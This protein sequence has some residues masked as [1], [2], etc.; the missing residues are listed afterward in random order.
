MKQKRNRVWSMLLT[1]ALLV[2]SFAGNTAVLPV[3]A[4][5]E[6]EGVV[7]GEEYAGSEA[8]VSES[9]EEAPEAA[10]A[11]VP[12]EED[13]TAEA[14]NYAPDDA[15]AGSCGESLS[16]ALED[17]V[18]TITG[19]GDMY[20]Y[21]NPTASGTPKKVPWLDEIATIKEVRF[22]DGITSIG[23]YS[24][25]K[26]TS[27]S[28]NLVIPDGVTKIG[29]YAFEESAITGDLTIP[30]SVTSLGENAFND[31]Q[32][33]TGELIIRGGG[34]TVIP[35]YCFY[36]CYFTKVTL[37]SSLQ[38]IRQYAFAYLSPETQTER[39][40]VVIPP[41]VNRIDDYAFYYSKARFYFKGNVPNYSFYDPYEWLW[42]VNH[43]LGYNN[44]DGKLFYIEGTSGWYEVQDGKLG[45]YTFAALPADDTHFSNANDGETL[46]AVSDSGS[47]GSDLSWEISGTMAGLTLTISGTGKMNDFKE[48]QA[49]WQKYMPAI[50]TL[51]LPEGL[52]SIGDYAFQKSY[53]L[54]GELK[55]PSTLT[56]IGTHAFEQS[57]FYAAKLSI[58]ASVKTIGDYAFYRCLGIRSL[59]FAEGLETI[60]VHA[61]EYCA[62]LNGI[63]A[64]PG[65]LRKLDDSAFAYCK[66]LTGKLV[67]RSG[68]EEIGAYAF[69]EAAINELTL[70]STLLVIK[71]SAFLRCDGLEKV[72]IPALVY[73]VGASA[74]GQT[75]GR[76]DGTNGKLADVY[77]K[78]NAPF[79][80][81][82]SGADDW[83]NYFGDTEKVKIHYIKGRSGWT[84]P[85]SSYTTVRS[86]DGSEAGFSDEND[87]ETLAEITD[88]GKCGSKLNWAVSGTPD[89]LT[90]TITGSGTMNAF[91]KADAVPWYEY[92]HKIR[93]LV[94]PAELGSISDYAFYQFTAVNGDLAIPEGVTSIGQWAF[95]GCGFGNETLVIPSN[96]TTINA[97][98]FRNCSRFSYLEIENGVKTIGDFAFN[99]C[100][101]FTGDLEIPESVTSIGKYAFAG[102]K[103]FSGILT[104]NAGV[105]SISE[106][107]FQR[108]YFTEAILPQTLTEIEK[109]AFGYCDT[110]TKITIPPLV[111]YVGIAFGYDSYDKANPRSVYFE[112]NAPTN[113]KDPDYAPSTLKQAFGHNSKVTLYYIE[114]KEGWTSP[115]WHE[116]PTATWEGPATVNVTGVELTPSEV[117]LKV[118]A[119]KQLNAKVLPSNATTKTV[120][121][122]SSNDEVATVSE[123]GLVTAVKA[124]SA[125][126]TVTTT[127]G[128]KTATC[129]VT[130][131]EEAATVSVNGVTVSPK[132]VSMNVGEVKNLVVS[133]SP[134]DATD[135]GVSFAS[136]KPAVAKVDENGRITGV[137]SGN[138]VITVT[139]NDGGFTDT[140]EVTVTEKKTEP[141]KSAWKVDFYWDNE[142]DETVLLVSQSVK[143][144]DTVDFPDVPEK[145]GFMLAG[146]CVDDEEGRNW[147]E[148][149][150][151]FRDLDLHA[152]FVSDSG[153]SRHS[154]MDPD[155]VLEGEEDL[156]MVKG[157]KYN[158]PVEKKWSS[159]A[160]D[161]VS[162]TNDYKSAAKKAGHAVI[163]G[164]DGTEEGKAT[165]DVYVT[166]PKLVITAPEAQK[167]AKVLKLVEGNKGVLDLDGMMI[168]RVKDEGGTEKED[169]SYEY[170][171][172]WVTSNKEVALVDDGEVHAV[173]KGNARITAYICG[174]TY[175]FNVKVTDIYGY[176]AGDYEG[177]LELTPLQTA[178]VK[179]KGG[180][181][182]LSAKSEWSSPDESLQP[183]WNAN[184]SK[185]L[186][187]QN[188]V[189]RV[190]P[191]GKITAIG[192]GSVDLV[193]KEGSKQKEFTV[194]VPDSVSKTVYINKGKT[195]NIKFYGMKFGGSTGATGS[196]V[197]D[198]EKYD[199]KMIEFA[200]KQST[201]RANSTGKAK[202]LYRYDPYGTGGFDYVVNVFVEDP[203][204]KTDSKLKLKSGTKYT[205]ELKEG[206]TYALQLDG[207]Y[208][209]PA[210]ASNKKDVAFVDEMGVIEARSAGKKGTGKATISAKING[211]KIS[212]EVTV[213]K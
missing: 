83:K 49:P 128:N 71:N 95:S 201:I 173:A 118:G 73:N 153:S 174:K 96:V 149:M 21:D 24:F 50:T 165:Y 146:W 205:L 14:P 144:G 117:T 1:F 62:G 60:G 23:A 4:G 72:V 47:C 150:P 42:Q 113:S 61:F 161:V 175:S 120:S 121:Y 129:A 178:K 145:A 194:T 143:D 84:N 160:P 12:S 87:T 77:F 213:K 207:V 89:D 78:G 162:I 30:A 126:I 16:Y 46:P 115:T 5:E 134:S 52:T 44:G 172:T 209:T 6:D 88:G 204:L 40:E 138:A 17:G 68:L 59:E 25:Y 135:P 210:Y 9:P 152:R 147:D 119:T 74:F 200:K 103:G 189:V 3:Q 110:L 131:S 123:K 122:N 192:A 203:K 211:T 182:K 136:D 208:Q 104:M 184:K 171:I 202:V 76:T 187:Y 15:P 163:T 180:D 48:K 36:R 27:L 85:W 66:N 170:D 183:V 70:S 198:T 91:T 8:G 92:R 55:L 99:S 58:P 20:D 139:T 137:A 156:F 124:G 82:G 11:E 185:I 69:L 54:K 31:C 34:I 19:S 43:P 132:T 111:D 167:G 127:D 176:G 112:G 39:V 191:A 81:D 199:A 10:P 158:F 97:S 33:L 168:D 80:K 107:V 98:A 130:V 116:Y 190:T 100:S 133:V 75:T 63:Y 125:T 159:D 195:K 32:K 64:I 29:T 65:S 41:L 106:G 148:T 169:A 196:I 140:C 22:P 114:G 193:V 154:G 94:L 206:E 51:V 102:C 105:T 7:S 155:L 26:A 142:K 177:A 37:P 90:L 141:V 109:Q 166:D 93:H 28:Q 38:E 108:C 56:T 18:L 179:Y 86:N 197:V 164:T 2:S 212:V 35:K 45:G 157:Q 79:E 53:A 13:E 57:G 151:V 101:G 181:F 188:D 186:Y 67:F